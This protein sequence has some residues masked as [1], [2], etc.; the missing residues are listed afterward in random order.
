MAARDPDVAP[1]AAKPASTG[2]TGA[3]RRGGM[4]PLALTDQGLNTTLTLPSTAASLM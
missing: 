4:A 3:I 2:D 1:N